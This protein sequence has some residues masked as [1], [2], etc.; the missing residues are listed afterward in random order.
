MVLMTGKFDRIVAIYN[1]CTASHFFRIE[2]QYIDTSKMKLF[3]H[4]LDATKK[5]R[6]LA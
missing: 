5:F 3:A 6:L 2:S 4:K 1:K